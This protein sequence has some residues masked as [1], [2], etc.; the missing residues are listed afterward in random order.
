MKAVILAGGLGTRL[1]PYTMFLPK[2]MLP[3]GD[4]PVLEHIIEWAR[5][6]G[7]TE[8]VI[9]VSYLRRR[10][11]EYFE[12][13][14]RLGVG[15]EYAASDRPLATAGQLKTAE[16]HLDGTF[17]CMYGDSVFDFSLR[18]MIKSH[19]KSGAL[20]TMG[21]A[22][23]TTNLPYGVIR[24]RGG[25]VTG[26]DEKPGISADVNMGCYVM[27]KEALGLVPA[28]RPY[29]MDDLVR[30]AMKRGGVN[31]YMA[32]GGFTDIGDRES[33]EKAHQEQ[34]RRLGSI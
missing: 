1:Q 10:I 26:W 31:G 11:E 32:R 29:G 22:R 9:C 15:I 30:R 27:E 16:G 34:I 24:T 6:G 18:S 4:K 14:A 13:G 20:V 25:R 21:L 3:L 28:G 23:F 33:Y 8:F 2:P 7:I 5:G 17:A 19:K 12:D